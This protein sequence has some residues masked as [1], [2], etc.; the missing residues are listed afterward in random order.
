MDKMKLD[1]YG[2]INLML[3]ISGVRAD[4]YHTLETIMQTVSLRDVVEVRR[5]AKTGISLRCNLPYIP[6]DGRNIAWKAAACFIERT[7]FDGGVDIDIRKI[8]PVGG[9]MAGGSTDA[10]AVLRILNILCDQPLS[11]QALEEAALTL[12]ADV[13]FCLKRGTYLCEGIGEVMTRLPDLPRCF[14]VICKPRASVSSRSAYGVYDAWPTPRHIDAGQMIAGLQAKDLH[15]VAAAVGNAFEDPIGAECPEIPALRQRLLEMGALGAAMTGS[16]SVVFGLFD[17]A[18]RAH[19]AKA[20]LRACRYRTF[21][22]HP[23]RR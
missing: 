7:G 5:R 2:K 3:N 19:K 18:V 13:P 17:D 22:V 4:G 23:V 15:A 6:T 8:I 16:G 1:A 21:C 20:A 10:A 9:G 12:G 14:I 11:E